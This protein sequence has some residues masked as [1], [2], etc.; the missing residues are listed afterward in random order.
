MRRSWVA[1]LAVI[2]AGLVPAG[3]GLADDPRAG[4]KPEV[5]AARLAKELDLARKQIEQL[6][7]DNDK[8]AEVLTKAVTAR[9]KAV[10][11]AEKAALRQQLTKRKLEQ[12]L[13][14]L[15]DEKPDPFD[16]DRPFK[17]LDK[18][19]PAPA[20]P[21][22]VRGT[23]TAYKD[24]L[25]VLSIGL[26]AGLAVGSVLD[27][28]RGGNDGKYLG[29]VVVEKV[30]PKEAVARFKPADQRPL[31]RLKPEQLPKVGDIVG[32]IGDKPRP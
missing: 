12:L 11:A 9:E 24:G 10:V 2:A 19:Q 13:A 15:K 22:G 14:E 4:E 3:R 32:K 28:Y 27:L 7:K 20:V 29:T 31:A 16:L 30:Y 1:G 8:L 17:K 6:K 26:D 25:A 23:L 18:P 5:T 21:E